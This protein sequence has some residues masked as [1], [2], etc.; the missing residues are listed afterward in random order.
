MT[1]AMVEPGRNAGGR[2]WEYLLQSWRELDE[3]GVYK[4]SHRVAFGDV[5]ELPKP[6]AV[7]I[8]TGSFPV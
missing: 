3:N 6:F 5:V 4:D 1:A 7:K 8:D 2:A